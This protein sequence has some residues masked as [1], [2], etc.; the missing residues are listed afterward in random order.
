LTNSKCPQFLREALERE[1]ID[2]NSVN[3]FDGM[4]PLMN[5]TYNQET[6]IVKM[7]LNLRK[8]D[9]F[10]KDVNG[11]TAYEIAKIVDNL[12]I[13]GLFRD[14]AKLHHFC[15]DS[16][17]HHFWRDDLEWRERLM[18]SVRS[19]SIQA[20]EVF[21]SLFKDGR[22]NIIADDKDKIDYIEMLLRFNESEE[23]LTQ[24]DVLKNLVS[25]VAESSDWQTGADEVIKTLE[26]LLRESIR[27]C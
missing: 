6:E 18:L 21:L 2:I 27:D 12:E 13:L 14:Y 25:Y 24:F 8:I 26:E 7:L 1:G 20:R 4:T 17:Y 23:S 3:M 11:V 19:L 5:A 15:F 16:L 9:V 10:L 22:H